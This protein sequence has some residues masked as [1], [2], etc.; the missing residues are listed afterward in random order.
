MEFQ[1]PLSLMSNDVVGVI[2]VIH[3]E[4]TA[5]KTSDDGDDSN[6]KDGEK[7]DGKNEVKRDITWEEFQVQAAQ[8]REM[9]LENLGVVA[10][11]FD[12]FVRCFQWVRS[13]QKRWCGVCN[14]I[15]SRLEAWIFSAPQPKRV[16]PEYAHKNW[17]GC[18]LQSTWRKMLMRMAGSSFVDL[19]WLFNNAFH[20]AMQLVETETNFSFPFWVQYVPVGVYQ[21]DVW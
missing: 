7:S 15:F 13:K 20:V 6:S 8:N 16:L 1:D 9:E 10:R 11:C 21:L 2:E 17:C 18:T 4:P 5:R 19:F 12:D 14:P 3:A